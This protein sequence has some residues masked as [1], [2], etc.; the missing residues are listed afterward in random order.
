M[1]SRR[2]LRVKILQVLFAFYKGENDSITNVEKE[3][4]HSVRKSY[5]LYH[6]LFLLL[7]DLADY[8]QS[9]IAA[10][11]QKHRPTE[12]D[13]NPNTR[14]VNN[15]AIDLLREC[16]SLKQ[17]AAYNKLSWVNYPEFIKKLYQ[18]ISCTDY[19]KAYM[20]AP[21]CSF[22]DDKQLL[23]NILNKELELSE[24]FEAILEEQS[25]YW[26][27]DVEFMVSIAVKT[28]KKLE[29][30]V[31]SSAKM[32]PMYRN[33]DDEEFGRRLLRKVIVTHRN[34]VTLIDEYT[35]N[36]DVDRIASMD[37]LIME[38]AITEILEF[39]SIPVKVSFNEYI[40]IAKFYSTEQS[41]NFIN[42]VLDKIITALRRDNKIVKEGRGLVGD[43]DERLLSVEQE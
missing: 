43:N 28:I 31:I 4:F 21:E 29:E 6:Y 5:D 42:G 14:F 33:T 13:L 27:D 23:I 35:K 41:S 8:A 19:F 1:I 20:E 25:I 36:W 16:E 10:N 24:D 9:R 2:L 26:N 37:I 32:L 15:K 39:T 18:K 11:R 38:M 12:E 7:I 34:N 3:F 40:E 30:D 17:Y 22:A